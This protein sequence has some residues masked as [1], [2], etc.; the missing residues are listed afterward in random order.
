MTFKALTLYFAIATSVFALYV[1]AITPVVA[2]EIHFL[3]C[4]TIWNLSFESL[5]SSVTVIEGE[6]TTGVRI[7]GVRENDDL[8]I[9]WRIAPACDSTTLVE[10]HESAPSDRT[11]VKLSSHKMS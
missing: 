11:A 6:E 7:G 1:L 3:S 4:Q 10:L 8:F 2:D 9:N 5:E